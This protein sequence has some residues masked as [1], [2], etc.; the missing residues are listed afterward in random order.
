MVH[1]ELK[2]PDLIKRMI[3]EITAQ[4][5][6][7]VKNTKVEIL[8]PPQILSEEDARKLAESGDS[9]EL[10]QFVQGSI[11]QQLR[12]GVSLRLGEQSRSGVAVRVVDQNV[13]IDLTDETIAELLGRHM[14]PR[15]QA[16]LRKVHANH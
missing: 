10:L 1:H 3:L 15:F 2:Q 4:A 12:E 14:L 9:D 8:L 16:V 7:S 13:E 6:E 5:S 11:G